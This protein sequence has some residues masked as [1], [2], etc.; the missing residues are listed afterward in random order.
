MIEP[1]GP[2]PLEDFEC[3]GPHTIC[4]YG[5]FVLHLPVIPQ[6]IR[7]LDCV[8]QSI[9]FL[10]RNCQ[11]EIASCF[12]PGEAGFIFNPFR[13]SVLVS[14]S[15]EAREEFLKNVY[16]EEVEWT[17]YEVFPKTFRK[18]KIS[19]FDWPLTLGLWIVDGEFIADYGVMV[20]LNLTIVLCDDGPQ[21]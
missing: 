5:D 4:T 1:G 16:S 17:P 14:L 10:L 11:E 20:H 7:V 2:D 3:H 18:W 15:K 6:L 21:H 13:D 8:S 19:K 12:G 9:L